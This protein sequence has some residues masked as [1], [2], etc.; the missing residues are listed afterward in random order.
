MLIQP[1]ASCDAEMAAAAAAKA[2]IDAKDVKE[3]PVKPRTFKICVR[4]TGM[5]DVTITKK[6]NGDTLGDV[7]DAAKGRGKRKHIKVEGPC[8]DSLPRCHYDGCIFWE[9]ITPKVRAYKLDALFPASTT[10]PRGYVYAVVV[11]TF[12]KDVGG[13]CTLECPWDGSVNEVRCHN[14][15]PVCKV[16]RAVKVNVVV[17]KAGQAKTGPKFKIVEH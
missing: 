13:G 10:L 8:N 3:A 12:L 9:T 2:V 16:C 5:R 17:V 15:K 6:I 11:G 1:C 4:Q 7:I 14:T